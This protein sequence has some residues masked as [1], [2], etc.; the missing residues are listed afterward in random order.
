MDGLFKS[1]RCR[2]CS[3]CCR[4]AVEPN[5]N[6][7]MPLKTPHFKLSSFDS[8]A[9]VIAATIEPY[10]ASIVLGKDGVLQH[11]KSLVRILL[12]QVKLSLSTTT[13]AP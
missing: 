7:P 9:P 13:N 5:Q 11:E 1:W 3:T 8:R 4:R 10:Q 2:R 6:M 12:S